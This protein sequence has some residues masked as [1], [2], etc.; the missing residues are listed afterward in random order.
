MLY[1][2]AQESLTNAARHAD[3]APGRADP[4]PRR[5][6]RW[7]CASATTA[8][9]SASPGEGAGIRGMRERA[10]LI[11]ATLDSRPGSPAGG[12]EVRLTVPAARKQQ[13]D[14]D[15]RPPRKIRILLA[16]DH[17]LVRRGSGSSSTA[18]RT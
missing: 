1:R 10:L 7:C 9:A 2:V 16:D 17:A 4:A 13:H 11:G 14:H 8:A 3:A 18:S 5:T 15:R 12:T 6:A